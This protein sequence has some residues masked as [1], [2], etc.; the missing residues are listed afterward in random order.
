MVETITYGVD[1]DDTDN[2]AHTKTMQ[3]KAKP[4]GRHNDK[5]VFILGEEWLK[6]SPDKREE[7]IA[8]RRNKRNAR[9]SG[10]PRPNALVRRVNVHDAQD[11]R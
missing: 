1:V 10:N 5:L 7:I 6:L 2:L 8:S 4:S 9:F 3:F 11:Q